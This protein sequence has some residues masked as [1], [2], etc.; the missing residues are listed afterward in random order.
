[1][2]RLGVVGNTALDVVRGRRPRVGGGPYHCAR[3]LRAAR[4]P[5]VLVTK[6]AEADRPA[7]LPRLVALGLHVEWKPSETTAGFSMRY[8]GDRRLMTVDVVGPTW[9]PE[10]ARG[11]VS[12]ALGP[13]EWVHVA[14]LARSDFPAET[15]AALARGRRLSLDGQ[16]LVRRAA[17]GPLALDADYDPAVLEH[18]S[19]LKLAEEEYETIGREPHELGVREV[20]ITR[21]SRGARVWADGRLEDVPARPVDRNPTGA[22]DAFVAAYLVARYSGLRPVQAARRASHVVAAVLSGWAP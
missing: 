13:A 10:D 21:G 15:L 5:A 7:L 20:L 22:G 3:G 9:T 16:G 12:D 11:W 1:V 6:L 2:W 4:A 19:V 14:P 8:V 17:T 18:V